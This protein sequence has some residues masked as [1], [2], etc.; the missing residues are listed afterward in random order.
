MMR[1]FFTPDYA[2]VAC[3]MPL[4]IIR[5]FFVTTPSIDL[6]FSPIDFAPTVD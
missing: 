2:I 4:H 6:L 5:L 3:P 1:F